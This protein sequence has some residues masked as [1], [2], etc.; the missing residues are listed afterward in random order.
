MQRKSLVTALG[1]LSNQFTGNCIS[2][3]LHPTPGE[4]VDANNSQ[5]DC[6][7]SETTPFIKVFHN[8][9]RKQ[10]AVKKQPNNPNTRNC[11]SSASGNNNLEPNRTKTS[12]IIPGDSILK[13]LQGRN[14][15]GAL[16]KV[17]VSS[18]PGCITADMTD[19]IRPLVRRKPDT[20]IIHVGTNSLRNMNSSSQCADHIVDHTCMV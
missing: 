10:R 15:S 19:H 14:L 2:C 6:D 12:T 7:T 1:L 3:N 8:R 11:E 17:Q 18:F 9:Q 4:G 20:I 13:H 5:D 16:S